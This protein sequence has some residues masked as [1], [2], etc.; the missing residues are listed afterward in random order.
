MSHT[1]TFKLNKPAHQF[2]A[3]ESLGFGIRGGVKYWDRETKQDEWTNF[4]AVLFAKGQAQIDYYTS[5]LAEGAVVSVSGKSIKIKTFTG[6]NGNQS[7]SLVLNNADLEFALAPVPRDPQAAQKA[8]QN[9][10]QQAPQTPPQADPFE[11]DIPW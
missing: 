8:H 9:G 1:V 6:Q 7:T 4:E 5:M 10:M 11:D 2:Q 3:G